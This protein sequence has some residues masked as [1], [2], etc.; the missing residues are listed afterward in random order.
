M[1]DTGAKDVKVTYPICEST[2]LNRGRMKLRYRR[3]LIFWSTHHI[4]LLLEKAP[5]FKEILVGDSP[6]H[7]LQLCNL[8][9]G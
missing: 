4:F 3:A 2:T 9:K 6:S 1:E 7:L 5:S 8:N